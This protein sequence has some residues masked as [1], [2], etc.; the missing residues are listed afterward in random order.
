MSPER[1]SYNRCGETCPDID[2]AFSDLRIRLQE[3]VPEKLQDE[4]SDLISTCTRE[5]KQYGTEKLRDALVDCC[6]ERQE[7]ESQVSSL[8]SEVDDL[9]EQLSCEPIS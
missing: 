5:V 4:L 1:E 8:E 7:L 9:K 3:L 2:E 6:K